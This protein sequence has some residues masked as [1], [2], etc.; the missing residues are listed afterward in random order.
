LAINNILDAVFGMKQVVPRKWLHNIVEAFIDDKRK[1]MSLFCIK[2]SKAA[3]RADF[4]LY[5][6]TV[7]VLV[8]FLCLTGEYERW[9][10][11][12]V[13]VGLGLASWT[14]I[15]Y[16]LHRLVMHGFQPFSRWHAQHHQRPTAL[17][18][19]PT[20][21]SMLLIVALVFLPALMVSDS[22][23][24]ACALT[25]AVV[26]GYLFYSIMRHATHHWRPDSALACTA[27][28]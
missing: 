4:V 17:I 8:A 12:V 18:C 6:A 22:L 20:I 13:L 27:P 23:W 11:F 21:M 1:Y 26:V 10:E 7:L 28:Q 9:L 24:R 3:Y 16:V 25:L 5:G 19:T 14:L 2:L 15:E